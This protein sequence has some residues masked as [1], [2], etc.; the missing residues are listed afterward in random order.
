GGCRAARDDACR[1]SRWG[2]CTARASSIGTG[3]AA[4]QGRKVVLA[5]GLACA[6]R[7]AQASLLFLRMT[8]C[9]SRCQSRSRAV[10]R[11]SCFFLP[12]ARAISSLTLLPLQYIE[13]GT[14]V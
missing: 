13:V 4:G 3:R 10:S 14:M 8:R 12:L 9:F 6:C 7:E 2:R 5:R 11:L 1:A